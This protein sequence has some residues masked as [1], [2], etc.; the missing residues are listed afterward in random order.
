MNK[1]DAAVDDDDVGV[2]HVIVV[3]V[4]VLDVVVVVGNVVIVVVVVIV[5]FFVVVVFYSV[6]VILKSFKFFR[7]KQVLNFAACLSV[8]FRQKN[9]GR[10]VYLVIFIIILDYYS[11]GLAPWPSTWKDSDYLIR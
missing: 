8:C 4:F 10:L 9:W 3:V 6:D 11:L 5:V 1:S 2:V 7:E